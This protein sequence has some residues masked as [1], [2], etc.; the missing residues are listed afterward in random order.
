M[1]SQKQFHD[2]IIKE[3]LGSG[4][5]GN[6]FR[7]LNIKT[8]KS[9][10]IKIINGESSALNETTII[11]NLQGNE[12]IIR[13][14]ECGYELY[15]YCL[16]FELHIINLNQLRLNQPTSRFSSQTSFR[17]LFKMI[18]IVEYIHSKQIIH[19]DIKPDNFMISQDGDIIL[20]DFGLSEHYQDF[21]Y[22]QKS[23]ICI[24]QS[25]LRKEIYSN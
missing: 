13:F 6:V 17:L 18:K 7:C 19:C 4:T 15:G 2:W 25:T 8:N 5:Y 14:F 11:K 3:P 9:T 21:S 10:A 23:S 22:H 12:G 24:S 1:K 16:V 20:I